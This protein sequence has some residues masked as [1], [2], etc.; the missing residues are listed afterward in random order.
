MG[1]WA[2]LRF[3]PQSSVTCTSAVSLA[4]LT[5]LK[6][7]CLWL[8]SKMKRVYPSKLMSA[9]ALLLSNANRAAMNLEAMLLAGL[10]FCGFKIVWSWSRARL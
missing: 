2:E 9:E 3:S 6:V 4:S 1:T 7:I 8:L 5:T 10:I